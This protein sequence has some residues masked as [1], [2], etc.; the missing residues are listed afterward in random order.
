[1]C[2][3]K[4]LFLK[5]FTGNRLQVSDDR[6]HSY[7]LKGHDFSNLILGVSLLV[8]DYTPMV[9]DYNFQNSNFKTLSKSRFAKLSSGNRLHCLVIDYQC[10]D[11]LEWMCF[12]AKAYQ[13]MRLFE[14]LSFSWSCLVDLELILKQCL[15]FECLLKQPCINS[16][17]ASSKTYI[18]TLIINTFNFKAT[19]FLA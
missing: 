14:A 4:K 7:I 16:T 18:H 13:P 2:L 12:E 8:I 5:F 9:I 1:M 6:L 19:I 17:F 11:M 3:F 10:L 15:T